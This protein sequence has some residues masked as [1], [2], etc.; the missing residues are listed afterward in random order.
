MYDEK[1]LQEM[2]A[3]GRTVEPA[4]TGDADLGPFKLLPGTW[5][6]V[7]GLP[8]RGWNMIALPFATEPEDFINY[9]L[10]LN[11][12]NEELKFSVV[13]KAVPNRGIARNNPSIDTDQFVV[14]LDYEQIITQIAV[15]DFP[16]SDKRGKLPQAI[17]HE[18][19]LFLNM[20]NETT[21]GINIARMGTVP[22]G[23][24]FNALGRSVTTSGPPE[25][26]AINGLPI[27]VPHNLDGRYLA[28]YKHFN[29]QPFLGLFNP[30]EP[31]L[32]LEAANQDP[33][34]EIVRTTKLE[35]DT[36]IEQGGIR[37]IP[38][39]VRQADAASMKATFWI[40]ELA[41]KDANGEP[42]LRLQYLQI[43]MLDFF[44]RRDGMPGLIGWPHVSI[45]TMEK[46][47]PEPD[48]EKATSSGKY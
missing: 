41:E 16:E 3:R 17:H 37:N 45:N 1:Q 6:N 31:H 26:P 10:L 25:I 28:P 34:I 11:Q 42:K 46:V 44:S 47:V 33:N 35:F 32:L 30:V 40:Q 20:T 4:K 15:D 38:F 18:P 22:H 13:D 12:Y 2:V 14:T 43:V 5:K 23:N 36:T 8:G 48:M 21:N 39:I 9:R 24:A 27:G 19:G 29:D 7:P